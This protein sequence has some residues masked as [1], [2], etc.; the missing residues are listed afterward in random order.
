MPETPPLGVPPVDI[1]TSAAASGESAFVLLLQP[2]TAN[3]N[4]QPAIIS[5][6]GAR[7][8]FI[9]LVCTSAGTNSEKK[10]NGVWRM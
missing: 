9:T 8:G 6:Q 2:L 10:H 7:P 3:G 1:G 5:N 4:V